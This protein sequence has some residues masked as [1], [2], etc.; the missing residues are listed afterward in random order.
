MAVAIV[1]SPA[2]GVAPL[3]VRFSASGWS[4]T[5][6]DEFNWDFGDGST[7]SGIDVSHEYLLPGVYQ[8]TFA[9]RTIYRWIMETATTTITVTKRYVITKTDV[10]Y[11]LGFGQ[12]LQ[13]K[14]PSEY[15]GESFPFPPA[16][17]GGIECLDATDQIHQLVFDN[18]H[19]AFVEIGMFDG[20]VDSGLAEKWTDDDVAGAAVEI[21]PRIELPEI[22]GESEHFQVDA[23]ESYY[24]FRPIKPGNRSLTGY[25]RQG[26]RNAQKIGI[27]LYVDGSDT[28]NRQVVTIPT[29]GK[30]N[31]DQVLS[32]RRARVVIDLFASEFILTGYTQ[33]WKV[34]DI[35]VPPG[36]SGADR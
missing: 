4:S 35:D 15:S 28:P 7:G 31:F 36:Y 14:G 17:I 16:Q 2:S 27:S 5:Y 34:R 30:I 10:C 22:S 18:A 12:E 24:Y 23:L 1:A 8:V 20:P 11:R 33:Y 3:T 29:D 9:A 6:I 13:G 19:G 21:L 25:N 26:M 32:C